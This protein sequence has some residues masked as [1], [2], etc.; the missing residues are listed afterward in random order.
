MRQR[1]DRQ[2]AAQRLFQ[3]GDRLEPEPHERAN[4]FA[5]RHPRQLLAVEGLLHPRIDR[6]DP[7]GDHVDRPAREGEPGHGRIDSGGLGGAGER[8]I[9]PAVENR[10]GGHLRREFEPHFVE[11]QVGRG[12]HGYR[13]G[14]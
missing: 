8:H 6:I 10:G 7:R 12:C 11:G 2:R 3:A 13:D 9:G 1:L 4:A 5:N 14:P